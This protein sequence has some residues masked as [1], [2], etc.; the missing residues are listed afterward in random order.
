MSLPTSA[1]PTRPLAKGPEPV[2][3]S[4]DAFDL[5]RPTAHLPAIFYSLAYGLPLAAGNLLLPMKSV[6]TRRVVM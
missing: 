4:F 3:A 6:T 2:M 1:S 5:R